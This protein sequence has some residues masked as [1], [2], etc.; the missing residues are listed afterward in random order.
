MRDD[1]VP[2]A[3]GLKPRNA[4]AAVSP[5]DHVL[6][7]SSAAFQKSGSQFV[8]STSDATTSLAWAL[9]YGRLAAISPVLA[10]SVGVDVIAEEDLVRSIDGDSACVDVAKREKAKLYVRRAR[11]VLLQGPVP[12]VAVEE[13]H[14]TVVAVVGPT[15][16]WPP[17]RPEK[18]PVD[19]AAFRDLVPMSDAD[20]G[21]AFPT[22]ASVSRRRCVYPGAD[23]S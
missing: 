8:S 17:A 1:E 20:A 7:G 21:L 12:A 9:P 11:E 23:V 15:F 6:H 14:S 22:D 3:E 19:A 4:D 18:F 10:R 2:L 5:A 13:I 16:L